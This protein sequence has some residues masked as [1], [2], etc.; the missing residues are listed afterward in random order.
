M[1]LYRQIVI[2]IILLSMLMFAGTVVVNVH[3]ARDYLAAQLES[4]A[5]DTATSLGLS[6]SPQMA[7]NDTSTMISMVDAIF[8]RGYYEEVTLRRIDGESIW[9][10]HMDVK[11]DSVPAWLIR[12]VKLD[13]PEAKAIIM[14]GWNQ[15]GEVYVKS[16]PGFAYQTLWQTITNMLWWFSALTAALIILAGMAVR[17]LLNPL[18]RLEA[19]AIAVSERRFDE[20]DE[21]PRTRELRHV[22][23]AMNFMT[24]KVKQMFEEQSDSAERMRYLAFQDGLTGLQNRRY[25]DAALNSSLNDRDEDHEGALLL[26]NIHDLQGINQRLGFDAADEILKM[27]ALILEECTGTMDGTVV[28]RLAGGDFAMMLENISQV[29]TS[30]LANVLCLEMMRLHTT[31]MLDT[32]KVCHVGFAMYHSGMTYSEILSRSDNALQLARTQGVNSWAVYAAPEETESSLPG[33]R[34]WQ[35]IVRE[36]IESE[37]IVLHAQPVVSADNRDSLLH[38]EI[39]LRLP[40][41]NEVLWTAGMFLPVVT[42][43][44][45]AR[46]LDKVVI[47]KVLAEMVKSSVDTQLAINISEGS[48]H[49][50]DF[51]AWLNA[52]LDNAGRPK[53]SIVFEI[54]ETVVARE[55]KRV[56]PLAD[57]VRQHGYGFAVDH[58]GRGMTTFGYL[59]SLRPDY[60]KIEG[61]YMT[62]IATNKDDQFF[63]DSLCKV[64][65]SLD[66]TVIAESVETE[67]QMMVLKE[68]GIDGMQG[69][70]I[71]RPEAL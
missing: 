28:A 58:F 65:H 13:A 57:V 61:I 68:L 5:Q 67:E 23:R 70:G 55:L 48:L 27:A 46:E 47:K 51:I 18:V 15:A 16:H 17:V 41:P 60:V 40:G 49:H 31:G 21:I 38:R 2:V 10:R 39:L 6:L 62:D 44:G 11:V 25:F 3:N 66:I 4:H 59:Q 43:M 45:L 14:S 33:R 36:A 19:Q 63:V 50:L 35:D 22:I 1:T 53:Q 34:E 7:N 9:S 64:A 20:I 29:E 52:A 56:Q 8:D 26:M 24:G 54:S 37:N 32:D 30:Q 42:Q 71:G 12:W 69:F